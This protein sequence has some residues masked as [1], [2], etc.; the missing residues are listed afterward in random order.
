MIERF[1]Q[2]KEPWIKAAL[3][4]AKICDTFRDWQVENGIILDEEDLAS[5][6]N[7]VIFAA[8][9][10]SQFAQICQAIQ[11]AHRVKMFVWGSD[12]TN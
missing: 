8:E 12:E 7:E 2:E 5:F 9:L 4:H 10:V 1:N 11:F 6:K 3:C